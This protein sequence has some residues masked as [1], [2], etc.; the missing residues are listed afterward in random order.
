MTSLPLYTTM[1]DDLFS[2]RNAKQKIV[3]SHIDIR[4]REKCMHYSNIHN[5]AQRVFHGI[6][7][8]INHPT[9]SIQDVLKTLYL[10]DL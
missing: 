6:Y 8:V 9:F 4:I 5:G 7:H 3:I 2:R 1:K 10:N